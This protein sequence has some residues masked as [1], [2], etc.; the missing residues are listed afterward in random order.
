MTEI[1]SPWEW[2]NSLE[3]AYDAKLRK[4]DP[5]KIRFHQ[6]NPEHDEVRL[7]IIVVS[8][9]GFFFRQSQKDFA[10]AT[11]LPRNRLA[12]HACFIVDASIT[13]SHE[14]GSICADSHWQSIRVTLDPNICQAEKSG[15]RSVRKL[16]FQNGNQLVRH[17]ITF[18]LL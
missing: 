5:V 11:M 4:Y 6:C 17:N 9:S 2:E 18:K 7:N 10:V 14:I 13:Q 16:Q 3:G 12:A 1:T 8:P 15:W